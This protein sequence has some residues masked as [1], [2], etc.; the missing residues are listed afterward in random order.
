[1]MRDF[2]EGRVKGWMPGQLNLVDV[3]DVARGTLLA[4]ERGEIGQAYLLVNENWTIR[5][6]MQYLAELLDRKP[7][8]FR[9]PYS[10]ALGFAYVEEAMCRLS[11]KGRIPM[12]TVTGVKLTRRCF[13]FDGHQSARKLDL[14]PMR[15][16][17]A[18]I[19]EALEGPSG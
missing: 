1:M 12:A 14:P 4:A 7:P 11:T 9:I 17:R 19:R 8:R 10:V 15:C 18:A 13:R 3:R 16:C 2:L 5:K 6:F